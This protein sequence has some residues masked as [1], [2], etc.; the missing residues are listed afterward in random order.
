MLFSGNPSPQ[1]LHYNLVKSIARIT[2]EAIN[3]F[4]KCTS[5]F[6]LF[7]NG[8]IFTHYDVISRPD[9]H[10]TFGAQPPGS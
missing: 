8:L 6:H 4:V 10:H 2:S 9:P 5:E 1:V 3:P 7:F